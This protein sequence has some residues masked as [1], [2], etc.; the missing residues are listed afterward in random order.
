MIGFLPI[1][2]GPSDIWDLAI[3]I[4][5]DPSSWARSCWLRSTNL[6]TIAAPIPST[7]LSSRGVSGVAVHDNEK[8]SSSAWL[9]FCSVFVKRWLTALPIETM[10]DIGPVEFSASNDEYWVI[11]IRF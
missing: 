4:N 6:V 8:G 7:A 11:S 9:Y 10:D 3:P 2:S 1:G 5:P